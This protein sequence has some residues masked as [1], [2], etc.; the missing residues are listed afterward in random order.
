MAK[1]VFIVDG[2]RTPI[3]KARAGRGPFSAAD[4]A[5]QAGRPL[6]ARNPIPQD[7]FDEVI[8]GCVMSS[9]KEA[10]IGR[11]AAL[12][13]GFELSV[14]AWTVQRNCASGMQALDSAM[15]RIQL[16]HSD[17]VLA[18]GCESMSHAPVLFNNRYVNWLG[19]FA[20][21]KQ[22]PKKLAALLDFRLSMLSPVFALEHGLTD[23]VVKLNM[24]QTAEKIA[25]RFDVSRQQMDEYAV[26]SHH[27]AAKALEEGAF[28]VELVPAFDTGGN[29]YESDDGVRADSSVEKLATLKP[30]FDK[31]Y[32]KV[33]A[34]NSS[35]ISDGAAWLILASEEAVEKYGLEP[36]AEI[37]T[38]QWSGLDPAEMGLG[39]AYA[40]ASVLQKE[41][42][43]MEDIDYWEFNEAFAGQVLACLEALKNQEFCKSELGL[44]GALGEI[45]QDRLNIHGGAVACGHPVGMS[46]A[47]IVLHLAQI[48]KQTGSKRGIAS[49]CIGGGQGGAALIENLSV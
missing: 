3:L 16:G 18:G 42:L 23:P 48:L 13:L 24:G 19:K 33:T 10:N 31:P 22:L 30:V 1:R 41:K 17:L 32:G 26:R 25:Y 8:L 34:A 43:T 47:R 15:N 27:R 14:P 4:L 9:A 45:D 46:G 28:D 35:Q 21:A 7:A 20:S 39:P 49:L 36:V 40:S 5:V 37:K 2:A 38:V 6:L 44:D 11:V 29:V 12:R